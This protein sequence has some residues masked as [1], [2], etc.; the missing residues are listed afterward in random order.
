MVVVSV[1]SSE[2]VAGSKERKKL[3]DT[4]SIASF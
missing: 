4:L 2:E 3:A 1:R